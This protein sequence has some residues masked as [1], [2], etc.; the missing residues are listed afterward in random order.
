MCSDGD[1]NKSVT[2]SILVDPVTLCGNHTGFVLMDELG[3][4]KRRYRKGR[5]FFSKA[6]IVVCPRVLE[7]CR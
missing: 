2:F 6:L 7:V 1:E 3:V 5:R 4:K